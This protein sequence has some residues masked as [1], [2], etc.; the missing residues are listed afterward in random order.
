MQKSMPYA[1]VRPPRPKAVE[2][3]HVPCRIIAPHRP[4]MGA[5]IRAAP[6]FSAA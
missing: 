1:T 4:A 5:A 2:K 6:R 3:F